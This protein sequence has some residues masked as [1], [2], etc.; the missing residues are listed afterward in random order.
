MGEPNKE[1]TRS[2]G[3]SESQQ[4]R[5]FWRESGRS[6]RGRLLRFVHGMIYLR[7][8]YTYVGVALADRKLPRLLRPL[9][10]LARWLF[11]RTRGSN[12]WLKRHWAERYHGKV[13]RTDSAERLVTLDHPIEIRAT[14]KV[15]PYSRAR[16]IVLR[17]PSRIVVLECACRAA[18]ESPCLPLDVCLFIGE[19]FASQIAAYHPAKARFISQDE[20]VRILRE[21]RDRGHVHHV[22]FKDALLG[23]FYA[24]CNCC[25][26][27]C[28][29]MEAYRYGTSMLAPSGYVAELSEHRCTSCGRCIVACPF[30][31]IQRVDGRVS[32]VRNR[33]MG[34]GVC[35]CVCSAG[36]LR[37][38]ETEGSLEPLAI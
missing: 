11:F 38:R 28:G 29:A 13:V 5:R 6:G 37:L 17:E 24:I 2:T 1:A 4:L 18:R 27:C 35:E 7:W 14:E 31:A 33:C 22:F 34:C 25:S 15:V 26:C 10:W 8:Q 32:I 16:D 19:P 21:E 36:A 9:S 30:G 3:A 12:A 23:R 20:A